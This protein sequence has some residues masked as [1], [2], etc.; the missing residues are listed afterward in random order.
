MT[1]TRASAR[2]AGTRFERSIADYAARVLGDDRID[3]RV[4]TGAKDRGDITGLR[5][6]GRRI[7]LELKDVTRMNLS[8]WVREAQIEAGNDDALAG[9]VVHKRRG[10]TDP[11]QQYVTA[12]VDD[13]LALWIGSRPEEGGS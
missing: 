13:F 7:V 11:G 10:T 6:R 1:R 12:T 2:A 5:F 8:G 3:R 4:K 9:F